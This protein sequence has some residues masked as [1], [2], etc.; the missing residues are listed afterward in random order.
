MAEDHR[1]YPRH[2]V[3]CCRPIAVR[4]LDDERQPSGRWFLSDILDVSVGG[5]CLLAAD[6]QTPELGEW[7][8]LD[9]RAHPGFGQIRLEAKLR[10]FVRAHFALTFGVAFA[11]PLAAVPELAVE[12]RSLRRD[13]NLEEWALREG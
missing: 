13:P 10:W 4:H 8:L 2:A 3:E 1:A 7:L 6:H 12:R 9:L 5:M 11:S